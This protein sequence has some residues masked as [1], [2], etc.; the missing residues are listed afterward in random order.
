MDIFFA[1]GF[2]QG[3]LLIIF[4]FF[5]R[6]NRTANN[7]LAL[8]LLLISFSLFL[9]F[10]YASGLILKIPHFIG[11]D[12]P[13]PFLIP[14][15]IYFYARALTTKDFKLKPKDLFHL[16]PFIAYFFYVYVN[17]F[18]QDAAYKI[19]FLETMSNVKMPTDL[20]I[21]SFLKIIQAIIYLLM[22]FSL[23]NKHTN[24]IKN[25]FS[26]VEK[27]NLSWLKIITLSITIIYAIR[28]VGIT[29][30]IFF[31]ELKPGFIE[32]IMELL[33]VLFIYIMAYFA[34]SQPEIFKNSKPLKS[35]FPE[36][37]ENR[38]EI[39]AIKP[40]YSTSTIS[41]DTSRQI[42]QDLRK[43]MVEEKPYLKSGLTIGEV[44]ESLGIHSKSL[45]Q[46]INEQV[47]VNF[48][49]FVNQYRVEEVKSKLQN[50]EFAHFSIL[51]IALD[52]GFS[53]KSSFNTIFKKFT[54]ETPSSYKSKTS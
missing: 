15:L 29:L 7:L 24:S 42:L 1:I 31:A 53:S 12:N 11:L 34:L 43:Y 46:V 36:T 45:S 25:E 3:I 4:L 2:A 49:N 8:L 13:N 16:I 48:F 41:E 26:Y 14:P 23:L 21:S 35:T 47:Q 50:K 51:G 18:I 33:N 54:G 30:P 27:I 6:E 19:E 32:G 22:S 9:N 20:L 37:T 10:L 40:K 5:K 38:I 28:L 52:S 39:N 44:A 17:F